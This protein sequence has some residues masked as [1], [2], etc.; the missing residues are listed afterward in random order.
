M[1]LRLF[2]ELPGNGLPVLRRDTIEKEGDYS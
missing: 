2:W 1:H